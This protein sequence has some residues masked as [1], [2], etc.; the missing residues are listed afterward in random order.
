MYGVI[1]Q[2]GYST[3]SNSTNT[4]GFWVT[5]T[6]SAQLYGY[7]GSV[8][9][10]SATNSSSALPNLLIYTGADNALGFLSNSSTH[11]YSFHAI[12][13]GLSTTDGIIFDRILTRELLTKIGAN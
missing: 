9:K 3:V 4:G 12:M 6:G 2:T 8:Q 1:N 5:R 10:F 7:I 13:K 11:R